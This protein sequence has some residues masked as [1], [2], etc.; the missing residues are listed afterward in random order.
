MTPLLILTFFSC[1]RT[2]EKN[3]I[4]HDTLYIERSNVDTTKFLHD[5]AMTE[6][7]H[8]IDTVY[9]ASQSHDT[10]IVKDSIYVRDTDSLRYI[11]KERNNTKVV[12]VHDTIFRWL[13]DTIR[14][15]E[16][17]TLTVYHYANR[18]DSSSHTAE[19]NTKV[20]KQKSRPVW[21]LVVIPLLLAMI[22]VAVNI[23]HSRRCK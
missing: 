14:V 3:V 5:G 20:I 10:L 11:Y 19:V 16:T 13:I 8:K 18:A 21:V 9:I 7:S 2:V 15:L 4:S 23:Y 1:T 6:K 22:V 12:S 17:D